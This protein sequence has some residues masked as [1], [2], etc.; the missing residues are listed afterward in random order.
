[1][2]DKLIHTLEE[3][4]DTLSK[5]GNEAQACLLCPGSHISS[6]EPCGQLSWIHCNPRPCHTAAQIARQRRCSDDPISPCAVQEEG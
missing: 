5:G 2:A 3:S 1:M 4:L 6:S